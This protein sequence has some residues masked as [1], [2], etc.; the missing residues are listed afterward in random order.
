MEVEL[1]MQYCTDFF[2]IICSEYNCSSQTRQA[3]VGATTQPVSQAFYATTSWAGVLHPAF[4]GATCRWNG[5]LPFSVV[6]NAPKIPK[7]RG[8]GIEF[9][10]SI[11]I[12]KLVIIQGQVRLRHFLGRALRPRVRIV[13]TLSGPSAAARTGQGLSAGATCLTFKIHVI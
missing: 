5:D 7:Q 1:R 4:C 10:R 3:G 12:I 13:K 2:K 11:K 8:G 9:C 6:R